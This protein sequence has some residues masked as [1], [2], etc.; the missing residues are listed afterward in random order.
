M[1][2][3][4]LV[5]LATDILLT[6]LSAGFF[7]AWSASVMRG[8]D[9][10]AAVVA[11]EAMNAVNAEIR[12]AL[13]APVF[14]GPLV[15][16]ILAALLSLTRLPR[17]SAFLVLAGVALYAVGTFGVTVAIHLPMNEALAAA[18][19]PADPAETWSA[20][21]DRWTLW[22]HVR[23]AFALLSLGALVA[24]WRVA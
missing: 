21:S 9:A 10:T 12:N 15:V 3:L 7:F 22:N 5:A 16:G 19:L 14:F 6:A 1:N 20:Y 17:A 8:L 2:R 23:A 4:R 18:P 11:I 24:A 13:F